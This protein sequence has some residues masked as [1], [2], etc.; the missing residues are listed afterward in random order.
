MQKAENE[1]E[2]K[3]ENRYL[4]MSKQAVNVSC[5]K[6]RKCTGSTVSIC[7]LIF[8]S[9]SSFFFVNWKKNQNKSAWTLLDG[10]K[11]FVKEE[12]KNVLT[13]PAVCAM[14]IV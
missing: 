10:I 12:Q 7:C 4:R 1:Y 6:A 11:T 14:H 5:A 13:V 3:D 8:F 9:E 2:R